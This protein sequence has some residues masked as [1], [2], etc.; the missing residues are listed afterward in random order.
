MMV[1]NNLTNFAAIG[2]ATVIAV[3]GI[4]TYSGGQFN[5]DWNKDGGSITIEG[6]QTPTKTNDCLP[7]EG[8][9]HNLNCDNH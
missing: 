8:S 3:T 9:S 1:K 7:S 4:I 6:K 2:A 5:G